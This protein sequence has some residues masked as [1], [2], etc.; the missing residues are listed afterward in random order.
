MRTPRVW[1][2]LALAP[3]QRLTLPEPVA[4]HLLGVLRLRPGDPL[5]LFNGD[6]RDYTASLVAGSKRSLEV[7][8]TAAS[9]PEPAPRVEIHLGIGIARAERMTFALQKATEL[10]VSH[11][12]LLHTE[13]SVVKLDRSRLDQRQ[14]HWRNI[15]VSACEQSGRR[16]LPSL[17]P[18][19]ALGDWLHT[20]RSGG[21]AIDLDPTGPRTLHDI[22]PP[23][24][25]VWLL[26]GPEGG[27]SPAEHAEAARAGFLGVRLGPRIL[28]AETAPLAAI[29]AIQTL[30]GDFRDP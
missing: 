18:T 19:Q 9:P 16:R 7:R 28:R 8:L 21:L 3:D 20:Q 2:E 24:G 30:W 26:I 15:L 27:L 14:M 22:H 12:T 13:R 29:A 6:G 10:G 1:V 17:E 25:P 5:I 11:I 4:H 23:Q